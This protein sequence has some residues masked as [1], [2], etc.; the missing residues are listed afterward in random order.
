M[1]GNGRWAESRGLTRLE[2]HHAGTEN[3]RRIIQTF[4]NHGVKCLT[5]YAFSTENWLRPD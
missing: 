1:D 3:I 2:G 5:L 4:A